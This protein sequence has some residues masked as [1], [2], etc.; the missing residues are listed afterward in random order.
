MGTRVRPEAARFL[1]IYLVAAGFV[2]WFLSALIY[3]AVTS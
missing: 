1:L 2:L 3:H